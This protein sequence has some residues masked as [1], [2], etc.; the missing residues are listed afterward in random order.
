MSVEELKKLSLD[1]LLN[2]DASKLTTEE[3]AYLEKRLTQTANR[4]IKKLRQAKKV[5]LTK[6]SAK[7]KRGFKT[8]S[9]PKGYKPKTSTKGVYVSVT[10][11]G[12]KKT[13]NVRNKK[14]KN[15]KDIQD[16]LKKKTSTVKGV[17]TQLERYKNVIKNT[18]GYE[19]NIT[20]RQAKRISKLMEKAKEMGLNTGDGNKKLSGS[21]RV[22]SLIVDIVKQRKYVK[23]D[24][25]EQIIQ[26]A[27]EEGY[28][29]A[30]NTLHKLKKEDAEGLDVDDYESEDDY[31]DFFDRF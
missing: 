21:P 31:D 24:D 13:I 8:Y 1:D 2:V 25:A 9:A 20:D 17:D 14:A 12:R 22:L 16:F 30:Q 28:E 19:G 4:R 11:K 18:T 26:K 29:E 23:N 10:P 15:V 6:L 3:V 7:E 27:I 5:G